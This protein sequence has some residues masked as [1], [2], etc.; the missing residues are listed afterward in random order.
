MI[1]TA[2]GSFAGTDL[3]ATARAVLGELPDRAPIVELPD[4]GPQ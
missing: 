4:R 2:L 3:R 1:A